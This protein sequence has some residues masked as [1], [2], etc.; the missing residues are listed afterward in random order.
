MVIHSWIPSRTLLGR[1]KKL[2]FYKQTLHSC[3]MVRELSEEEYFSGAKFPKT[4]TT[5]DDYPDIKGFDPGRSL[6]AEE[7]VE[8]LSSIGFQASN[9]SQAV[10]V[11]KAMRREG[12]TVFLAYTSNMVTSGL[13]DVIRYLVEHRLVDVLVTSAGG[14]EEDIIK[15]FASFKLGSFHVPG[16][17]LFSEGV[18]RTGNVFIPVDRYTH[19]ER[20]LRPALDQAFSVREC[21]TVHELLGE[22]GR[23]LDR[24]DSILTWAYRNKIP[25]FCPGI[26]D[27][28]FGEFFLFR[29]QRGEPFVVDIGK[30][31]KA[32][33][34]LA[35]N[36]ARTGAIILG[37]G[38]AKH[39]TLLANIL[40]DGLDYV[41]FINTGSELDGSDSG[42]RPD[43]AVTW[44]KIKPDAL[45]VKVWCD[46]T[47]AFPLLVSAWVSWERTKGFL[48]D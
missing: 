38:V 17:L 42:A 43:E 2:L 41:V 26:Q 7:L 44:A 3:F 46:A 16:K 10:E 4:T 22:V 48:K 12:A 47:I 35:L 25:C 40:R 18:S 32:I 21:W 6:S 37:G 27:G 34:D 13:R 31:N 20:F 9:L 1:R 8:C 29:S 36:S 24:D 30:E 33:S 28:A 23:V 11:V 45:S 14:V 19:L 39:F 15:C 5:L